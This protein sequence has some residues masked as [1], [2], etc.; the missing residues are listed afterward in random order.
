ML[1]PR[2]IVLRLVGSTEVLDGSKR[3]YPMEL[4]LKRFGGNTMGFV[5][6]E[7]DMVTSRRLSRSGRSKYSDCGSSA[8]YTDAA[9]SSKS[10]F[11]EGGNVEG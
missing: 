8:V 5:R 9:P 2:G 7:E 6:R 3:S 11:L 1:M 4:L 10:G